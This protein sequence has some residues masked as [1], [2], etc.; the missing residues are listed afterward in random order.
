M[1]VHLSNGRYEEGADVVYRLLV[2]WEIDEEKD[3]LGKEKHPWSRS[4]A[5][6]LRPK[7]IFLLHVRWSATWLLNISIYI[8]Q[9]AAYKLF[10]GRYDLSGTRHPHRPGH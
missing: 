2:L 10:A 1:F 7:N 8:Y 3:E 5:F 9:V 4:T 6:P